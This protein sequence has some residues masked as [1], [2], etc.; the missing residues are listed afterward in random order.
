MFN[1]NKVIKKVYNIFLIVLVSFLFFSC[2][3]KEDAEFNYVKAVI[4]SKNSLFSR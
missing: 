1:R 2:T 4:E 3:K